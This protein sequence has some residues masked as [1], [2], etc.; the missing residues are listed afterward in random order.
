MIVSHIEMR[1][2]MRLL[3]G[4]SA[5]EVIEVMAFG[6]ALGVE[7]TEAPFDF[8]DWLSPAP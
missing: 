5:G 1:L 6:A 8:P 2:G 7:Y 3:D 4:P